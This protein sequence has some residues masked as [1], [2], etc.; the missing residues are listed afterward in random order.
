ML[1][2]KSLFKANQIIA[3]HVAPVGHRIL[4]ELRHANPYGSLDRFLLVDGKP[5]EAT[6]SQQIKQVIFSPDGKLYAAICGRPGAEFVVVDGK[7]G[8]EYQFIDVP[9]QGLSV[10][11]RTP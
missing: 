3:V 9:V 1:E 5:A 7:K 6:L 2:G 4:P 8:Q 11:L 10:G